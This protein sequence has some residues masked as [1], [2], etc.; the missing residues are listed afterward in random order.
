M[1]SLPF[2][3][4]ARP[5]DAALLLFVCLLAAGGAGPS[6]NAQD[7]RIGLR[8]GPTFGF[9]NDSAVPFSSRDAAT[10]ANPRLDI[11]VGGH[12]SVPVTEHFALQPELLYV[13]KGGH[14]SQPRSQIYL[15]ERYRVSYL[16]A[17][18]LGRRD[19]SIP[20]PL[21][22]HLV[23]GLS[24]DAALGGTLQRDLRTATVNLG[25]HV[26]LLDTDQLR[27]WDLGA[28]VGLSL[29]Y[30]VD[31]GRLALE[32][33]YTPGFR[34]VF[35]SADRSEDSLPDAIS[36]ATFKELFPL[37]NTRSSL[38]HDVIIASITYSVP[39]ASLF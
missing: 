27:R 28:L 5:R 39:L 13:Q 25:E 23:A 29:G 33:R 4:V 2:G 22:L 8:V 1:P 6:A 17:A 12:A 21:S 7:V 31:T 11:H 37:P 35:S 19:I 20:T 26:G 14:F 16:Q 3:L 36:A 34:T 38:R 24:V 18:L 9:L 10:N 15:V 30:P 32:V